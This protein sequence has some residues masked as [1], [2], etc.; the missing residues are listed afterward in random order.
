MAKLSGELPASFGDVEVRSGTIVI[1]L[2]PGM[3]AAR[4]VWRQQQLR[5]VE[6]L[7]RERRWFRYRHNTIKAAR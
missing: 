6:F 2:P 7:L 1:V 4:N 5:L 3:D